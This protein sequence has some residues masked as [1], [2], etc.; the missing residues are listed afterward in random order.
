VDRLAELTG[1]SR[2]EA[3]LLLAGLP[4]PS[5]WQANFLE[6]WQREVLGLKAAEAKAARESLRA[7]DGDRRLALLDAAM[8]AD[9]AR[10]WEAGADVDAVARV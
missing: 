2:A 10:L 7:I 4:N 8:P 6:P 5:T 1:I 3:A 9:P